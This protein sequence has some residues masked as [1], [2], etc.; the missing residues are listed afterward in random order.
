MTACE[1]ATI[2]PISGRN[3]GM[4]GLRR[5]DSIHIDDTVL[6]LASLRSPHYLPIVHTFKL[7][8]PPAAVHYCGTST[9]SAAALVQRINIES[10]QAELTTQTALV[11]DM[12]TAQV[13]TGECARLSFVSIVLFSRVQNLKHY[14][15]CK[16]TSSRCSL[17][18]QGKRYLS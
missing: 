13:P 17:C 12:K 3:A 5:R 14:R 9:G 1:L 11:R 10:M 4:E 15:A 16:D 6:A 7:V 18:W 2:L 8:P